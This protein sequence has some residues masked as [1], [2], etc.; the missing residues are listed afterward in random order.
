MTRTPNARLKIGSESTPSA[1]WISTELLDE[2]RQV[3]SAIYGRDV[4]IAEATEILL[5]VKRLA[6]TLAK[7]GREQ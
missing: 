6:S 3:W 1:I 4:S 7:I 5:S 2:T